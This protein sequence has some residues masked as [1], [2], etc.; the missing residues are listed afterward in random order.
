MRYL[1]SF[2]VQMSLVLYR[3]IFYL[4][5]KIQLMSNQVSKNIF[6]LSVNDIYY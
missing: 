3:T 2:F 5:D 6:W 1:P 4:C